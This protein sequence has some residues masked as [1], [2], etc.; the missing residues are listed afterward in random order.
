MSDIPLR[1]ILTLVSETT[2]PSLPSSAC[3]KGFQ[4][5]SSRRHPRCSNHQNCTSVGSFQHR[6]AAALSIKSLRFNAANFNSASQFRCFFI[7]TNQQNTHVTAD[8][9]LNQSS[10]SHSIFL[11]LVNKMPYLILSPRPQSA[12]CWTTWTGEQNFI[13]CKDQV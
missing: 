6:G 3:P 4:S 11:S 8:D 1:N 12:S 5:E 10:I 7:T 2:T 9:A 13:I